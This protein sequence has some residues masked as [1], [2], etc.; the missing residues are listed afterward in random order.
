MNGWKSRLNM[1]AI[2]TPKFPNNSRFLHFNDIESLIYFLSL[3]YDIITLSFFYTWQNNLQHNTTCFI[4]E[5]NVPIERETYPGLE[6]KKTLSSVKYYSLSTIISFPFETLSSTFLNF[7]NPCKYTIA[8]IFQNKLSSND[9]IV[10]T[11]FHFA[12][13]FSSYLEIRNNPWLINLVNMVNAEAARIITHETSTM[14]KTQV[15]TGCIIL[16]EYN[17]SLRTLRKCFFKRMVETVP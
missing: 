15:Y 13:P 12:K 17:L 5:Y 6:K 1:S 10:E 7:C 2:V 11:K 4:S 3:F 9:L 16:N 8:T 14:A